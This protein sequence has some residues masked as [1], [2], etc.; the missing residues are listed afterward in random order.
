MLSD[1]KTLPVG[2]VGQESGSFVSEVPAGTAVRVG[3]SVVLAGIQGSLVAQ[4]SSVTSDPSESFV[5]VYFHVPVNIFELRFV[6]V[7]HD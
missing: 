6:E 7:E 5:R 2:V 1:G 4:V 3:D